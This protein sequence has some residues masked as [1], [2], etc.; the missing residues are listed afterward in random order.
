MSQQYRSVIG[1]LM[2]RM[3][4]LSIALAFGF[5]A[6]ACALGALVNR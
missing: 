3:L 2:V 1:P 5:S 6:L 4:L